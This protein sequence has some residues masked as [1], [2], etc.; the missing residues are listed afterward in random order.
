MGLE[1]RRADRAHRLRQQRWAHPPLSQGRDPAR[2][3]RA[4]TAR[5]D[6]FF[7]SDARYSIRSMRS[8]W[9]QARCNP[10]GISEVF[11]LTWLAMALLGNLVTIAPGAL[12]AT[13]ASVSLTTMPM[14]E[15]PSLKVSTVV[16]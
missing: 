7:F 10:V 2:P 15:L 9:D 4:L 1:I 14:A 13:S 5:A 3:G 6:Y 8:C 11:S 12:S 16:S